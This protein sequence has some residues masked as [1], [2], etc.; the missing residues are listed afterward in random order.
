MEEAHVQDR[1]HAFDHVADEAHRSSADGVLVAFR[2]AVEAR[3]HLH[4]VR[5]QDVQLADFA[6]ERHGFRVDVA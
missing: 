5:A 1:A 2:P 6:V 3:D 4:A